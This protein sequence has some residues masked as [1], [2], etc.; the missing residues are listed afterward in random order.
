MD[1]GQNDNR[2]DS[3]QPPPAQAVLGVE[4]G[5]AALESA[6]KGTPAKAGG[7][8]IL[9]GILLALSVIVNLVLFLA[10]IGGIALFAATQ[11]GVYAEEVLLAGPRSTKIA[12]IPLQGIIDGQQA[13]DLC[14]QLKMAETDKRVKGVIIRVDSPGGTISGSDQINNAIRKFRNET[15]KPTIAFMEG[16]AASGGYYTSVACEQIVAEPTTITGSIGVMFGHFVLE[17]LLEEKLGIQPVIITSGK[18]KGWPSMFAPFTDEQRQYVQEKLIA[19]AY[20]RFVQIVDDGRDSLTLSEVEGLADGSIY[21][22]QEALEAKLI[23]KVGYFEEAV[24]LV[25]SL[26]GIEKAQVVQYRKPFSFARFLTYQSSAFGGLKLDRTTLYE[27]NT[28][29][30]LYLWTIYQ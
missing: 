10:L 4:A 19:P 17:Q 1:F 3:A 12:V 11:K 2:M 21:G 18:K 20:K 6:G 14:D 29:Q 7:W 24:E 23:D 28:P 16:V 15:G 13:R 5:R 8:K 27:M 9:L 30:V 26:A 25:K 22:A